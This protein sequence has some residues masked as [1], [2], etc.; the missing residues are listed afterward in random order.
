M[1]GTLEELAKSASRLYTSIYVACGFEL[2]NGIGLFII[3]VGLAVEGQSFLGIILG[4]GDAE[5]VAFFGLWISIGATAAAFITGFLFLML[6]RRPI[7]LWSGSYAPEK[8]LWTCV[9]LAF[10]LISPGFFILWISM[11]QY[12][13]LKEVLEER[14]KNL[15]GIRLN[16][17]RRQQV[18]NDNEAL[19]PRE[20]RLKREQQTFQEEEYEQEAA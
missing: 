6:R 19:S 16:K 2:L 11:I 14:T 15:Q 20:I 12:Y 7:L 4:L 18:A 13:A 8:I 5:A 10:S 1:A 9:C 17:A 3:F